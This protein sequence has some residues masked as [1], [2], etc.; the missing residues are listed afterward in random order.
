[1]AT[2]AEERASLQD[3]GGSVHGRHCF[4]VMP[5]GRDPDE[6]RWFRGW[7]EAVIHPAVS[8]CNLEPILA[9]AE[10]Q[11]GAINDEIRSHLVFDPMVVVDL[12]GRTDR[13]P[14]NPNVMYELGIRHAFGL[15]LVIMGWEGQTLP[16]DVSNQRAILSRRDFLDIDPT[17][18][19][20]IKFIG[21]ASEGRFYNPMQAVGREAVIENASLA[22]GEESLLGALA[23]EV[24]ELRMSVTS[25]QARPRR[26]RIERVKTLMKK[27]TRQALWQYA[28]TIGYDASSWG[29]FLQ[30]P[31]AD[32]MHNWSPE[33]W[34]GY[35][36]LR[37]VDL[38]TLMPQ[39][40]PIDEDVVEIVR[41]AL[42]DQPWQTGVHKDV[43]EKTG[44]GTSI[45]Q[46]A[47][48]ELI[49]RGVFQHQIDGV[50]VSP[51]GPGDAD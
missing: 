41:G 23:E 14:P 10:E 1:M 45:V 38:L 44:L 2:S 31:V 25:S 12:G 26:V 6:Q 17:K 21:A 34:E 9:A 24:R 33:D 39:A 16:F 13:D 49:R 46:K 18:Q 20:L 8:A 37:R 30:L 40:V 47:I 11:P 22:L 7:Y 27:T 50:I 36:R 28:N 51:D 19:K 48:R 3:S 15:P 4:I 35:L 5:Y 42:P 43:S 29:K 32:E